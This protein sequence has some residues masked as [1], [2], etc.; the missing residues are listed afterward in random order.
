MLRG[1]ACAGGTVAYF[2]PGGTRKVYCYNYL[3][4]RWTELSG[5]LLMNKFALVIISG[6]LTSV[7]GTD[8]NKLFT[9]NGVKWVEKYPPM[10]TKRI[11]PAAVCSGHS[12]VVAGGQDEQ[13]ESLPT[14]EVMVT[15]TLQW[16]TAASLPRGIHRAIMTTC[17]DDLYLLGDEST[18][19]YSCSLQSLL[20]S[21][22]T[23]GK[24]SASQKTGVWNRIT[25]LSV[26]HSTAITL[27][28]QLISVGGREDKKEIDSV[29]CYNPATSEWKIIGTIP[30]SQYWPLVTTLPGD[31][32]IVVNDEKAVTIA[33]ANAIAS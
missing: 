13:Y 16:F 20:Q 33:I 12:L 21:Y 2:N 27:C 32:L 9:F 6:L 10:S 3:S 23:S 29:Y 15:N 4:K 28:G 26:S 31:K 18:H 1:A 30:A 11:W 14:V 8:S 17:G 7:G 5:Y 19:V 22:Q 24:A 25:D